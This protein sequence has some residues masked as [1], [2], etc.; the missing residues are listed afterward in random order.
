MSHLAAIIEMIQYLIHSIDDSIR[1]GDRGVI[2]RKG[3]EEVMSDPVPEWWQKPVNQLIVTLQRLG[4]PIGPVVV[5]TVP[6]RRTG[7]PR[8]TPI[9]PFQLDGNLYATEGYP[10]S[11]WPRNARAAGAGTLTRGRTSHR[12]KIVELTPDEAR[13][14][15]RAW[16]SKVAAAVGF[17]KKAGLVQEG[18]PDEFEALAGR[19]S[20]FS[21]RSDPGLTGWIGAPPRS[22]EAP[23]KA[24]PRP[25]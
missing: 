2:E 8:A 3:T 9:T 21:A 15:L 24:L 11:D 13:P 18:T 1:Y 10:G 20:G 22:V 4:L 16:P 5:L 17:S 12:V 6:G 19:V 14:V 7:Q 23:P 25:R